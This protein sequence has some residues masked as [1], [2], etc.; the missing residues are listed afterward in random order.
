MKPRI[1]FWPDS[2]YGQL[3]LIMLL[4]A[5]FL[6]CVNLY[7]MYF[8][9]KSFNREVL[10]VR[11]DYNSSIFLAL[12]NMEPDH[13]EVFLKGLARSQA[14][15]SQPFQ[16]VITS[17]EP[18]WASD[19]SEVAAQ[20]E[21]EMAK[22]LAAG[23]DRQS[24]DG[25]S[26]HGDIGEA[27]M[28]RPALVNQAPFTPV[29][30]RVLEKSNPDAAHP[31]YRD[32][33]FPL[34]QMV[35]QMDDHS[36]LKIT[37]PLEMINKK[38][39]WVQR[40]FLLIESIIFS[41]LVI[42]LMRRATRPIRRLGRV[43]EVFGRHPES[44]P[45]LPEYGGKE[46]R[47]ASRSFNR[48]RERICANLSER[49]NMLEA[50]GHDLRTPLAR[51]QLRLDRVQPEVLRG[52]LQANV[53]EI[54][55][56]VTQGL[57]L[58]RSL[59]VSEKMVPLDVVAFTQSIV[60]D[61]R[62]QGPEVTLDDLTDVA[63]NKILVR[64]R[65]TCLRRCLENLMTNAVKYGSEARVGITR[66]PDGVVSI[67]VRDRGPGIPEGLL[68]KI[69]EP[70][71]RLERSRN[72]DSGGTGLGLSIARNMALQNEGTLTLIN[73]DGGGLIARIILPPMPYAH[74]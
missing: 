57:E 26:P 27:Q 5:A 6:Q 22:A 68:E 48:M 32:S 54:W 21:I 46:A 18:R 73:A 2:L 51:I 28:T 39:V 17:N 61:L 60:D 37:Q 31:F 71:Y 53:E 47:E 44:V 52:K 13:R 35:I 9:Q 23:S 41:A 15:L 67:D 66:H 24:P 64:A 33:N 11:Y 70:Y 74:A 10:N 36:W 58:A 38:A 14:A 65:P 49:N 63:N 12:Q 29:R 7:T 1:R 34:L 4:G 55:S 59:H 3:V 30:T 25:A 40:I 8:I 72:R 20:A 19:K 69:F 56:I 16:F 62:D 45:P 43:A 42:W 50:M